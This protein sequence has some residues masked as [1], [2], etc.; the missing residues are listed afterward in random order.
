MTEK[1][2]GDLITAVFAKTGYKITRDDPAFILVELNRLMLENE[3]A[4]IADKLSQV[5]DD[6]DKTATNNINLWIDTANQATGIFQK[7]ISELEAKVSGLSLPDFL[8]LAEKPVPEPASHNR[9]T[10]FYGLMVFT[11][12]VLFGVIICLVIQNFK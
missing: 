4:A 3:A 7:K 1:S 2:T 12:G 9:T 5:T 11:A 8:A 6:F 10:D